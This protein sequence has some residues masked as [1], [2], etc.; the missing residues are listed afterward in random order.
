MKRLMGRFPTAASVPDK[1]GLLPL[2]NV[3]RYADRQVLEVVFDAF[4]EAI[5]H[6][7]NKGNLP[8]HHACCADS[9]MKA[10]NFLIEEYPEALTVYNEDGHL[11][12]H[13]ACLQ[14]H[15]K[16]KEVRKIEHLISRMNLATLPPTKAGVHPLLKACEND[17][18]LDV[19]WKL[20]QHS[21]ELFHVQISN[22]M[23][24]CSP[25]KR[26]KISK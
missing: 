17:A 9:S 6:R 15:V 8:L 21:P 11:P 7:T 18:V 2:H 22:E 5:H 3:A 13:C 26:R 25:F 23:P 20:V 14:P 16:V 12:F 10:I 1:D 19:I 24:A 4:P